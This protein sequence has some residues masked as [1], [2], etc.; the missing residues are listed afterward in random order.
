MGL[1]L[2]AAGKPTVVEQRV[3][4]EFKLL[5]M[6]RISHWTSM[7]GCLRLSKLTPRFTA[8]LRFSLDHE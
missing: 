8:C 4:K 7:A 1:C 2:D 3:D 5:A 6:L